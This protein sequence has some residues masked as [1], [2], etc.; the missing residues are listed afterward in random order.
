MKCLALGYNSSVIDLLKELPSLIGL[1]IIKL[2][3][4]VGFKPTSIRF[5]D[6]CFIAKLQGHVA[7][8][9][10]VRLRL[11]LTGYKSIPV[12]TWP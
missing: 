11:V 4:S 9:P 8:F 10:A 6:D 12:L 7:V 2:V 5:R 1:A 3:P